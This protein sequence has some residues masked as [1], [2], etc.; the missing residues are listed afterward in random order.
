MT[1][2]I[3]WN[4]RKEDQAIE[5]DSVEEVSEGCIVD[6]D[7]NGVTI[8]AKITNCNETPWTGEITGFPDNN[9][10]EHGELKI[11]TTV[12]FEDR[13]VIRCAA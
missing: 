7:Y 10:T 2:Q 13:H 4:V 6:L 3:S 9:T 8:T 12:Q 11:G 5:F 1:T